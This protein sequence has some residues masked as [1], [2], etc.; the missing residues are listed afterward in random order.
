MEHTSETASK[1]RRHAPVKH[2]HNLQNEW[3]SNA[4]LTLIH[5]VGFGAVTKGFEKH[6]PLQRAALEL[7]ITEHACIPLIILEIRR[8]CGIHGVS[9]AAKKFN[10]RKRQYF[11]RR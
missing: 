9:I 4:E 5:E 2:F 8:P 7:Y 6:N 11:I 10:S 3:S 1:R